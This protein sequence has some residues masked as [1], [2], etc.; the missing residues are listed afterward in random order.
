M[1]V[2]RP[3]MAEIKDWSLAGFCC[4]EGVSQEDVL[5]ILVHLKTEPSLKPRTHCFDEC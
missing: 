2:A 3:H 4:P 1:P 5:E